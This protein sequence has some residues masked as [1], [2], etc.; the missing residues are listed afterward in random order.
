M[1]VSHYAE[2][3]LSEHDLTPLLGFVGRAAVKWKGIGVA[4]KFSKDV[5]DAIAVTT[6]NTTPIDCFTDLLSRWLKWAPPNHELPTLETLAEA[7][8][9]GTVGEE[10]MAS[11]LMK[12]FQRM[13]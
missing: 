2:Y 12:R 6:G 7:L 5:L 4:L 9:D 3:V 11:E 10:K 8:R 1:D 13:L